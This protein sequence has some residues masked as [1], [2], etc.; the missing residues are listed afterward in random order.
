MC[1]GFFYRIFLLFCWLYYFFFFW[2]VFKAFYF[3][4]YKFI[5]FNWR[6]ITLKYC[7]GF[8][9][10]QHESATGVHMFPILN[11]PPTSL[12]IPSL[13]FISLIFVLLT[14]DFL[15]VMIWIVYDRSFG[16]LG[17]YFIGFLQSL[18]YNT[19]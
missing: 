6:L 11:P 18:N 14:S 12:P 2:P 16:L 8:T 7:I 4:K 19:R 3:F 9:I 13:K 10:H 5:Y 1:L 17:Y 15:T